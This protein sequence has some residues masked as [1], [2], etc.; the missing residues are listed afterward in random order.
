[1]HFDVHKEHE[2]TVLFDTAHS[3]DS[4]SCTVD[5][6]LTISYDEHPHVVSLSFNWAGGLYVLLLFLI[7]NNSYQTY[8]LN[9]YQTDL[10]G[11]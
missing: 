10:Q 2:V 9:I 4:H 11:L 3:G 5:D 7:F 8:Y 6:F 1:M